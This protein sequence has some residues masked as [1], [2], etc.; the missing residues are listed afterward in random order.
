MLR[1]GRGAGPPGRGVLLTGR[2]LWGAVAALSLDQL[3]AWGVL[4]YAYAV[5]SAPMAAE[6]GVDRMA[7]AAAFSGCL[8]VA[9]WTARAIGPVLDER[10]TAALMRAG[11]IAGPLALAALAG[12][13]GLAG[14]VAI[15]A[16]LGAVHAVTLY[17][18]AFRTLVDWCPHERQR[19]RAMLLLTSIGGLASTAFLPLTGWLLEQHTWRVTVAI[20]AALLAAVLIPVRFALPLPRRGRAGATPRPPLVAPRSAT[21]LAAGLSLH[22]LASTGVFISLMWFLVERG[23]THAGA[24]ALAGVAGAA[25]VPGRLVADPLRRALGGRSILTVLLALQ[26]TSLLGAVA[27]SGPPSVALLLLF[28]AASG[29]MT[30]ERTT[31]LV[32]W[33]GRDT[34]G[35]HQGRLSAATSTARAASPF[36]V[37]V[38]HHVL[39]YRAVFAMLGIVLALAAWICA[40][41]A[42]A[43][44]A[45]TRRAR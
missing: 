20:L 22:A 37:E 40:A 42:R 30:L 34:F 24:A 32:E 18:P 31:V 21:Q 41:A 4:Y 12:V 19:T 27:A 13:G 9:G 16:A 39:P 11:A 23:L 5:L 28:G 14:L 25:Q 35:A 10:G 45:E 6:L 17:E 44:V 33:Y 15:F 43:R 26:A 38:G 36:L 8:L 2:R 7:V 29:M 3:V 1:A